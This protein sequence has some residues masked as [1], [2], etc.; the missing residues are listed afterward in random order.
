M[1]GSMGLWHLPPCYVCPAYKWYW[2][3]LALHIHTHYTWNALSLHGV[4]SI[5]SLSSISLWSS[6]WSPYLPV[7]NISYQPAWI[8]C[9]VTWWFLVSEGL[10]VTCIF[11]TGSSTQC[12][13]QDVKLWAMRVNLIAIRHLWSAKTEKAL[14]DP[15]LSA[16]S[17]LCLFLPFHFGLVLDTCMLTCTHCVSDTH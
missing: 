2:R 13:E 5:S 8:S 14:C 7:L 17:Y 9:G 10:F 16:S 3:I 11:I 4:S 1:L 6:I 12:V 15:D